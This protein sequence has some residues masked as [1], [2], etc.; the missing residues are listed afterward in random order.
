LK[1]P[2]PP[3]LDARVVHMNFNLAVNNTLKQDLV[4]LEVHVDKNFHL[5]KEKLSIEAEAKG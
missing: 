2:H 4:P 5:F 1:H 3:A